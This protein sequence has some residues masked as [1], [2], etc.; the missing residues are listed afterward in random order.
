MKS[1]GRSIRRIILCGSRD[2]VFGYYRKKD[3]RDED[4]EGWGEGVGGR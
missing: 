3:Q 4:D 2:L 1:G